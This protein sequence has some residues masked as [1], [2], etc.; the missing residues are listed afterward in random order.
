MSLTIDIANSVYQIEPNSFARHVR[1]ISV[2]MLLDTFVCGELEFDMTHMDFPLMIRR[3]A[4]LRDLMEL[5]M[6]NG[7]TMKRFRSIVNTIKS[8]LKHLSIDLILKTREYD[9]ISKALSDFEQFDANEFTTCLFTE[10][11][12]DGGRNELFRN[13]LQV[14]VKWSNDGRVISANVAADLFARRAILDKLKKPFVEFHVVFL[15]FRHYYRFLVLLNTN[16]ITLE[17]IAEILNCAYMVIESVRLFGVASGISQEQKTSMY[18]RMV[19]IND[20][21]RTASSREFNDR[22]LE[23]WSIVESR[24]T[25]YL[26]LKESFAQSMHLRILF[27]ISKLFGRV[28]V[29]VGSCGTCQTSNDSPEPN[30]NKLSWRTKIRFVCQTKF[31]GQM[32]GLL[33]IWRILINLYAAHKNLVLS[34]YRTHREDP[35]HEFICW[36]SIEGVIEVVVYYLSTVESQRNVLDREN[37]VKFFREDKCFAYKM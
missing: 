7:W 6:K 33:K 26:S 32:N 22:V 20:L 25:N 5:Y 3:L 12:S 4:G 35:K 19:Q 36:H 14:L 30:H 9:A 34:Q 23:A 15:R 37:V 18:F 31:A 10:K 21:L 16:A 17:A 11:T 28:N 29:H 13:A 8:K 1:G 2:G 24:Q 27:E